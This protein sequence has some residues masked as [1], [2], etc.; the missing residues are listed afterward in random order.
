MLT[1]T[2]HSS[3]CIKIIFESIDEIGIHAIN[4]KYCIEVKFTEA[5]WSYETILIFM[6]Y[7][8][9]FLRVKGHGIRN[10]GSYGGKERANDKANGA[11]CSQ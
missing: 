3:L 9:K 8:L 10:L 2:Y 7:T 6:K 11:K 1:L 4:K 5:V